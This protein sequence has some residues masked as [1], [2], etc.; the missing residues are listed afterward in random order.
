MVMHCKQPSSYI[1]PRCALLFVCCDMVFGKSGEC[2][3]DA[4]GE[5]CTKLYGGCDELQVD[6][7]LPMRV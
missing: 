2:G 1:V 4:H 5:R 6:L 3:A 7:E